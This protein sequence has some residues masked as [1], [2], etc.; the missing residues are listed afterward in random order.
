MEKKESSQ[1]KEKPASKKS[2]PSG[3]YRERKGAARGQETGP[4]QKLSD[5]NLKAKKV[6]ADLSK[7][8]ER[9]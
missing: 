2:T 5:T 1:K 3:S 8:E 6:D 9:P 7:R 4:E